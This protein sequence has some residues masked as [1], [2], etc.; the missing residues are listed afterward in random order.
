MEFY[1]REPKFH[2]SCFCQLLYI[3]WSSSEILLYDGRYYEHKFASLS[4]RGAVWV[5]L[6]ML[7][8]YSWF[9]AQ[10]QFWA[11]GTIWDTRES[12]PFQVSTC[13]ANAILLHY[14]SGPMASNF[15][16][17]DDSFVNNRYS[18]CFIVFFLST[19]GKSSVLIFSGD[20]QI[21]IA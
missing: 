6:V 1:R 17:G 10:K 12:N 4:F 13:K 19:F 9:C 15:L 20:F 21:V 5:T 11:W 3:V 14:C 7:R 2:S 18:Y 16:T 8:G